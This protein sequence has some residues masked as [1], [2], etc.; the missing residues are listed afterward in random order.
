MAAR[1]I[2]QHFERQRLR[3]AALHDELQQQVARGAYQVCL[4]GKLYTYGCV[5]NDDMCTRGLIH[6]VYER[7][8]E[9]LELLLSKVDSGTLGDYFEKDLVARERMLAKVASPH[10][11]LVESALQHSVEELE[12]EELPLPLPDTDDESLF[13]FCAAFDR[14]TD[15]E[16]WYALLLAYLAQAVDRGVIKPAGD[17]LSAEQCAAL[18]DWLL[19]YYSSWTAE[20]S[21]MDALHL[22]GTEWRRMFSGRDALEKSIPPTTFASFDEFAATV[23]RHKLAARTHAARRVRGP[24]ILQPPRQ[25]PETA[26][27]PGWVRM[28]S[29]TPSHRFVFL[30]PQGKRAFS[31]SAAW[32]MSSLNPPW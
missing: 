5:A 17:A 18:A 11:H 22:L 7:E 4:K 10:R 1:F 30:G 23:D 31:V 25:P 26:L 14:R 19:T 28:R 29:G 3:R 15:V 20:S 24:R 21:E 16:E 9:E 32:K 13:V 27:P 8:P 6:S 12:R 2:K